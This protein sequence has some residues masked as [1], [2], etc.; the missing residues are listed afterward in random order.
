M[1]LLLASCR[2]K[3]FSYR[4]G[5]YEL[6]I[7][8]SVLVLTVS[9]TTDTNCFAFLNLLIKSRNNLSYQS[10]ILFSVELN[11]LKMVGGSELN[12]VDINYC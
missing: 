1:R 4:K 8:C 9:A 3:C 2:D 6:F 7:V 12:I 10:S 5:I 11:E